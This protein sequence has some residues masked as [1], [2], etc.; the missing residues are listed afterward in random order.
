[1]EQQKSLRDVSAALEQATTALEEIERRALYEQPPHM[2][3]EQKVIA[4][5][6]GMDNGEPL[7]DHLT[8]D[9]IE[10]AVK[11]LADVYTVTGV[12]MPED[13]F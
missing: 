8:K 5:V 3:F 9:D 6:R 4:A 13:W 2:S 10:Q 1:M 11:T 7:K 12:K